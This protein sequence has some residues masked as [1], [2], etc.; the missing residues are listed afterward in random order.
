T[1][2]SPT[3]TANGDIAVTSYDMPANVPQ[4]GTTDVLD[5]SDTRLTQAVAHADPDAGGA[6][7]VWT[8]HTIAGAS[9][10]S[11]DRWYELLPATVSKRQE[12]NISNATNFVFNGAISPTM[13]GNEAVIQYNVGGSAQVA[14]IRASSRRHADT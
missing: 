8:Q 6:E 13:A 4:P 1:A 12:G 9:G 2:S 3:L 11:V 7:A 5:S 10:R 14:Q